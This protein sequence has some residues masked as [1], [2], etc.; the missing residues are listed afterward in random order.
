[1]INIRP[2]E[3]VQ[4]E[5][6]MP[7]NQKPDAVCQ[8]RLSNDRRRPRS[9]SL[10]P[11]A[12]GGLEAMLNQAKVAMT[13]TTRGRAVLPATA[14]AE[15]SSLPGRKRTPPSGFARRHPQANRPAPGWQRH[16]SA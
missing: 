1:M 16:G 2:P 5:E 11:E 14:K 15:F 4:A 7:A 8:K 3:S 12:P 13:F 6:R 9:P 10:A